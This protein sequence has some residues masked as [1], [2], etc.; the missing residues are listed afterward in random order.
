[1]AT[2]HMSAPVGL[3]AIALSAAMFGAVFW[4]LVRYGSLAEGYNIFIG[5]AAAVMAAVVALMVAQ[6][7]KRRVVRVTVRLSQDSFED[8]L[9]QAMGAAGLLLESE[10]GSTAIFKPTGYV[11]FMQWGLPGLLSPPR[12][13]VTKTA[14]G[15]VIAGPR[16]QL[17]KVLPFLDGV[18][19]SQQ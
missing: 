12:L 13:L 8:R 10:R 16:G 18:I 3:I 9:T 7:R 15:V 11:V 14:E 19:V 17:D 5:A 1:M 6:T 2:R 4:L